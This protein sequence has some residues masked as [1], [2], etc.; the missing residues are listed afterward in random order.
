MSLADFEVRGLLG[1]GAYGDVYKVIRKSSGKKYALKRVSLRSM[2]DKE[3]E[4][5]LNEVRFLASVRHMSIIGFLEA[6]LNGTR[7][8]CI[9]MEYAGCG[10]LEQKVAR[11]RKRKKFMDEE[12]IWGVLCQLG[13]ALGCLHAHKVLHRDIKSANCFIDARGCIKLGDS[14]SQVC[15]VLGEFGE[16]C[17]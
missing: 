12:V 15:D 6:F 14:L 10:D 16:R 5:T 17:L 8:L 4:D 13:S 9:V 11:Y 3:V 2:S 1:K 7:E